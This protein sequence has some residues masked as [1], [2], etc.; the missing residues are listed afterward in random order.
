MAIH[1]SAEYLTLSEAATRYKVSQR[2]LRRRI[3]TGDLPAL[4]CGRRIIRIPATALDGLFRPI[5]SAR[6]LAS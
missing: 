3:S 4:H 5:P 2:T 6:S 1:D